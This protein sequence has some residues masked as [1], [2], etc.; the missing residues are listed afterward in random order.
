[1]TL[2][3][4]YFGFPFLSV[5]C[6]F[7]DP[8]CERGL[9]IF[10]SIDDQSLVF[11]C[12]HGLYGTAYTPARKTIGDVEIF[13]VIPLVLQRAAGWNYLLRLRLVEV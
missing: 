13:L 10:S 2:L 7:V 6:S 11:T 8:Q 1:M 5:C 3:P 4:Y 12:S 9:T